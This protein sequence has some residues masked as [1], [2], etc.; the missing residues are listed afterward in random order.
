M[1]DPG[2]PGGSDGKEFACNAGDPCSVP[3]GFLPGESHGQRSLAGYS[4]WGLK[5]L[6]TAEWLALSLSSATV[7]H[8]PWASPRV[9]VKNTSSLAPSWGL[10]Y[11]PGIF[12]EY[13]PSIQVILLIRNFW[14]SLPQ[15][16]GT[17]Q[18]WGET[19]VLTTLY[20]SCFSEDSKEKAFPGEKLVGWLPHWEQTREEPGFQ[21]AWFLYL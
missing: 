21:W 5:E 12:P 17:L 2:L 20:W 6:D 13:F 10:D 9:L 8:W 3:P 16:E 1:C 14:N 15:K 11:G 7:S 19:D 18:R 4:L